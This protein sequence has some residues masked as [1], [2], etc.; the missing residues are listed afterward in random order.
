[1]ARAENI[2]PR[3]LA[4]ARESAGLSLDDAAARLGLTASTS[5]SGAEKLEE[6]ERGATFP[7]QIQLSKIASVYRRPLVTFY[8]SEPPEKASRGEDFRTLPFEVSARENGQLDALLRDIRAR[9]EMVRELIEDE[10]IAEPI[11]FIASVAMPRGVPFVAELIARELEFP[12]NSERNRSGTAEGLFRELRLRAERIGVFVLL[13]G[14]LGSHHSTISEQVFRGFAIADNIAPFVVINDQDAKAAWAFTLIH[15]LAHLWLGQTGISGAAEEVRASSPQGRLEQF[16]NDVAGEL[17]LPR[18]VFA[19]EAGFPSD[20]ATQAAEAISRIA[21]RWCVSESMVAY[22]MHRAGLITNAVY[23]ELSSR[24]G[25]RWQAL[26]ARTK[27]AAKE[28]ESGPSYY[29]VRQFKLGNALL[30]AVHTAVR[31]KKLTHTKAAKVLG[32]SPTSVE[33]LLRRY[34][35][36]RGAIMPK[37]GR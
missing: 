16:C 15:E 11:D 37:T 17:L 10:G 19:E 36:S 14:D 25:A 28:K 21:V 29:R 35:S 2:N 6:L 9:Q 8:M 32:V 30:A 3:I 12:L 18:R 5:L 31:E 4:W 7:T 24:Y 27:E 22:R 33:P 34:E 26:K 1:M 23:R 13:V 20:D